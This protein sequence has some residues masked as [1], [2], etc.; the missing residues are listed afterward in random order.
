MSTIVWTPRLAVGIEAIDQQHQELIRRL[1]LLVEAMKKGKGKDQVEQVLAFLED[2]VVIHFKD[3]E[4][5]MQRYH[6]PREDFG[7]HRQAHRA[8]V[9]QVQQSKTQ[10][11]QQGVTLSFVVNLQMTLA[12]WLIDHIGKTDV[13]MATY[14]KTCSDFPN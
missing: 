9:R 14:L 1:N 12:E 6:Y 5:V 10:L 8:F 7:E 4:T 13:A 2:Y 3:E 11:A